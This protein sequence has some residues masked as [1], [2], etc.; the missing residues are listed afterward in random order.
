MI[1]LL[2]SGVSLSNLYILQYWL[3]STWHRRKATLTLIMHQRKKQ[4]VSQSMW[5]MLN[6]KLKK[7]ITDIQ[8]ALD[9]PIILRFVN[10]I[11][12]FFSFIPHIAG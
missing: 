8:T 7:G 5:P 1:F 3:I 12:N 9:M 10:N 11:H 2:K 4:E 6:I